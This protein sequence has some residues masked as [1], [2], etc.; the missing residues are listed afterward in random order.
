MYNEDLYAKLASEF[1]AEAL[2][3]Y[4]LMTSRMYSFMLEMCEDRSCSE[5]SFHRDWWLEKF[6]E[7][8]E[9]IKSYNHERD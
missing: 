9:I 5:Y 6:F 3:K 7:L 1:D 2:R 4:C 8:T